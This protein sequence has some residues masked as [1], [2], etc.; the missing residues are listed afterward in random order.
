VNA[1]QLGLHFSKHGADFGATDARTY[2]QL[3]DIFLMGAL[4][5]N[6]RECRRTGGDVVRFD[7]ASNEYGVIDAAGTVRTF[8]KPVPCSEVAASVRVAT[9]QSGKCHGSVDNLSYFL[10]DC[11]KY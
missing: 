4:R 3:A 5:G 8:F 10:S 2:E 6:A 1:R 7:P 9:R 11:L